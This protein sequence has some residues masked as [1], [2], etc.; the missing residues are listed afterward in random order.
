MMNKSIANVV[1]VLLAC[2]VLLFIQLNRIQVLDAEDLK[3]H[4]AN[5]RT[6][7][8]DFNRARGPIV[9]SDGVVVARSVDT[10]GQFERLREYPEGNLYAHSAGYLTF[11]LGAQGVER[12]FGEDLVGR[13]SALQLGGLTGLFGAGDPTGEVVLT[14]RD[15]LQRLSKELLGERNGS[16]V[17]LDP[18]TGELLALW[19]YPSFDPNL[20][21]S[22]DTKAVN[23]TWRALGDEPGKPLLAKTYRE[24]YFPGSTFKVVTAAAALEDGIAT[25]EQPVFEPANSYTPPLTTKAITNF[26]GKTCGGNLMDWIIQ[27]C[28]TSFAQLGAERVGPTRLVKTAQAFGFNA[29]PP[30]NLPGVE[31]SRFPSNF[32]ERL[33]DPSDDIPAG[34]F[35]DSAK[36]A[37]AAIGQNDVS[38]TPLQMALVAAAVANDGAV[39]TPRIV[40]EIRNVKGETVHIFEPKPWL[41][42]VSAP[43][44]FTLAQAMVAVVEDDAGTARGLAVEDVVVG[45]KTGTAEVGV[46]NLSHAW[47]I[48]FAGRDGSLPELAIAV[49]VE[50]D[51]NIENQTGG[52]VAGPIAHGLIKHYFS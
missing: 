34:V 13:T 33:Q 38:A 37:Q 2:F 36:L 18:R 48:V 40:S 44:A 11:N 17:A 28:N 20:L 8:R 22:H 46:E 26:N 9:T 16:V 51:E 3:Q 7:Q 32:G 29:V 49:L 12:T 1:K 50:A 47:V 25:P 45:A 27:S 31:P 4:A 6:V 42:A 35:E 14:L 30:V 19:S 24:I 21:S 5:T 39:M 52:R 41:Q 10:E 23:D 43:T 15:D